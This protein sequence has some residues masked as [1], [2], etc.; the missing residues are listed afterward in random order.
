MRSVND[1]AFFFRPCDEKREIIL[2]DLMNYR[3]ETLAQ[4]GRE[5]LMEREAVLSL[6]IYTTNAED[7]ER[8]GGR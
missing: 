8:K 5:N 1:N 7:K 3:Q 2:G 4:W 6:V